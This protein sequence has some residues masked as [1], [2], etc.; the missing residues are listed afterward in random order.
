MELHTENQPHPWHYIA[1]GLLFFLVVS[2]GAAIY[3]TGRAFNPMAFANARTIDAI[4]QETLEHTQ[5]M[6]AL[7]EQNQANSDAHA[8]TRRQYTTWLSLG[9]VASL[10][11]L[12]ALVVLTSG[13]AMAT[14]SYRVSVRNIALA[15]QMWRE[16]R[17]QPLPVILPNGFTALPPPLAN[18]HLLDTRTGQGNRLAADTPASE[19]RTH[20][21]QTDTAA[22]ALTS[23]ATRQTNHALFVPLWKRLTTPPPTPTISPSVFS[24]TA[25]NHNHKSIK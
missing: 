4:Q 18:H 24:H 14:W 8:A 20:L 5:E 2:V 12:V 23:I 21:E 1:L 13:A 9:L 11:G 22:R 3:L 15:T 25:Q 17:T 6:N 10:T 19:H 7:A 16:L